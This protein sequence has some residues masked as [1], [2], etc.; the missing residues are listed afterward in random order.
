MLSLGMRV[1]TEGTDILEGN[2][3]T[4][5]HEKNER[6][7]RR[8]I[9]HSRFEIQRSAFGMECSRKLYYKRANLIYRATMCKDL[10]TLMITLLTRLYFA[11][12]EF[13]VRIHLLFL[14][15]KRSP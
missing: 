11:D 14:T 7:R 8:R 12:G 2:E 4:L 5:K 13:K 1:R 10:D 3:H 15:F 6:K 9:E